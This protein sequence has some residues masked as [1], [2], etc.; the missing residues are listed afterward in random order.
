MEYE[1]MFLCNSM[2]IAIIAMIMVYHL[3]GNFVGVFIYFIIRCEGWEEGLLKWNGKYIILNV[4]YSTIFIFFILK[5][6]ISCKWWGHIDSTHLYLLI[7]ILNDLIIIVV[8]D[9]LI[10][11]QQ[12]N[13]IYNTPPHMIHDQ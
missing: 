6:T 5:I 1:I 7:E 12:F 8:L 10:I 9:V 11:A 4:K 2:G 13:I 3:I